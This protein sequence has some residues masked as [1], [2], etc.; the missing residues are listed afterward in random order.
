MRRQE[1]LFTGRNEV[2]V[3]SAEFDAELLPDQILVETMYSFV[4]TGTE[5]A[6]LT[7]LQTVHYPLTPGNRA[8]G[9]VAAIGAAVDDVAVGDIVMAHTPHVS[10]AITN[11][12]R[13]RVPKAVDAKDAA[14]AALAL[15]AMTS[16]RVSAP[17]LGDRV[18]IVGLGGVGLIAAQLFLAAGLEVVGVDASEGRLG[19]A[20]ECGVSSLVHGGR[21]TTVDDV[22]RLTGEAGADI[23]VEATGLP[24]LVE[25]ALNMAKRGGQLVLLG[26]PRGVVEANLT[27]IL[28]HVH[29]WQEHGTVT[30]KG[31]HEW[32]F[33]LYSDAFTRH[34]IQ[35]NAETIFSLIERGKL[36]LSKAIGRIV[37]PSAAPQAYE[38]MLTKPDE[39]A[40]VLFD[41]G[42]G[43]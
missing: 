22:L 15:V 9:R 43:R 12:F 30:I 18:A 6:K 28:N 40:G 7:G 20:R 3:T 2:T 37:A 4:S 8:V 39:W 38:G 23:V 5:L 17:E 11:G 41:W 29:L 14:A 1:I 36:D 16:V 10:H 25:P 24:Q 32:Q 31:A 19:L 26:S 27:P 42:V 35:R 33:P 13:V 21:A 34:S